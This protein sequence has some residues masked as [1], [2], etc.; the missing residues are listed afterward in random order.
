MDDSNYT[1]HTAVGLSRFLHYITLLQSKFKVYTIYLQCLT[2]ALKRSS[3]EDILI[4]GQQS[5]VMLCERMDGLYTEKSSEIK[6]YL[7][8]TLDKFQVI[9]RRGQIESL[10]FFNR[11]LTANKLDESE[12]VGKCLGSKVFASVCRSSDSALKDEAVKLY[13]LFLDTKKIHNLQ[14]VYSHFTQKF[15]ASIPQLKKEQ[16]PRGSSEEM[17]LILDIFS[18]LIL[19]KGSVLSKWALEPSIFV[20]TSSAVSDKELIRKAPRVHHALVKTLTK[21]CG[22][23][24]QFA[25]SSR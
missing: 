19:G 21:H 11:I 18:K 4:T 7:Q 10:K 6:E 1:G 15:N 5:L 24:N 25:S 13:Q 23:H 14:E 2:A 20:L 9:S 16:G 3:D 8:L 17:L 12:L 22:A